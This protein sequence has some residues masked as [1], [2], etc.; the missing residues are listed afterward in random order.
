MLETIAKDKFTPGQTVWAFKYHGGQYNFEGLAEFQYTGMYTHAPER[1]CHLKLGG[2]KYPFYRL[3]KLVFPTRVE[4]MEVI[5]THVLKKL[6]RLEHKAAGVR[7]EIQ[8]AEVWRNDL[9]AAIHLARNPDTNSKNN[10]E[11]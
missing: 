7:T 9:C 8:D 10:L 1:W 5:H 6:E 2:S 11:R 4:A 3:E